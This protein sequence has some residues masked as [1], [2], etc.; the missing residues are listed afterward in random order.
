MMNQMEFE[1][2]RQVSMKSF[3]EEGIQL[4]GV[5]KIG[6]KNC[7][8][9]LA[10]SIEKELESSTVD[11]YHAAAFL[12]ALW[13]KGLADSE[14]NLRRFHPCTY[15]K[16][17]PLYLQKIFTQLISE[18]S[19]NKDEVQAMA[20]FLI[21]ERDQLLDP[22]RLLLTA[23][24]RIRHAEVDEYRAINYE[25]N[26]SF[27]VWCKKKRLSS[28]SELI[29][30]SNPFDG[31]DRSMPILPLITDLFKQQGFD[32]FV[33]VGPSSGPKFGYNDYQL[34]QDL[35]EIILSKD[36]DQEIKNIPQTYY[37]NLH[38]FSDV[39][40]HWHQLRLKLKKRPFMATLEKLVNPMQ[41]DILIT[42]VFHGGFNE[43]MLEVAQA[44]GFKKIFIIFRGVEG[45]VC[46]SLARTA[47]ILYSQKIGEA[48]LTE[49]LNYNPKDFGFDTELDIETSQQEIALFYKT[50]QEYRNRQMLEDSYIARRIR[51][52]L[53]VFELLAQKIKSTSI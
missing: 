11:L 9:E 48:Y 16:N 1:V 28:S 45:S 12:G 10:S 44:I 2:G 30:I 15:F 46:L 36:V 47:K 18:Q 22:I 24:L 52:N 21:A 26:N 5:G 33:P 43:K 25:I 3:L 51:W 17:F 4:I 34:A 38:E 31:F 49:E 20:H 19:L 50:I 6:S 35:N 53:I 8:V 41:S 40:L 32:C 7:S 29:Q 42:S 13:M 37:L 23:A 14:E 39:F 27:P